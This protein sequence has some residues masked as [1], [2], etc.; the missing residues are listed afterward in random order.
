MRHK[1]AA[2]KE[3]CKM[4]AGHLREQNGIYQMI[5]SW[6]GDDGRRHSKSL[7]TGL[8][9]KGNKKRDEAMLHKTRSE[10]HPDADPSNAQLTLN[11]FLEK[12]LADKAVL[13]KP[14]I[15]ADYA[16]N[17]RHFITPY[18]EERPVK[19]QDLCPSDLDS[20]FLQERTIK[21]TPTPC[22]LEI[23]KAL[24]L[25]LSYAVD[26]GLISKNPA[27][28]LNPCTRS[29]Q[30][31][32]TDFLLDWLRMMEANVRLSTY[33]GYSKAIKNRIIP[34]FEQVHPG[35]RLVDV[36]AKQIQDYY[37]HEALD[38]HLSVATIRRRHANIRKALQYA[39]RTDLIPSNPAVKVELPRP[40]KYKGHFYNAVQL[41][42]TFQ[43]FKDDPAEFGVLA[44]A[45][46]G[47]RR[48]EI[49]GLKWD[50][51]D[52]DAKT[53]TIRHTVTE[54]SVDGKTELY[55]ADTTKTK[56]SYRILPLVPPFEQIL[57]K[58]KKEQEINRKLCGNSYCQ[59]Y[60]DYI[61]VNQLGELIKPGYLSAHVPAVLVAH[62]MPRIRF[63]D[64]RHSCA[65]L[66]FSQGISL[67]EIQAWLG[68]STIST[69]ANIYTHLDENS[70]LNSAEAII[71][72]LPI[73]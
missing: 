6:K 53:I 4:V 58:M 70:K 47:L 19:L 50:A 5:L 36:T 61:Y 72:I 41:E 2:Q 28:D 9:V 54:V 73:Q 8:P 45:F 27:V 22:L 34:Y 1:K 46:Y 40:D 30:I 65:T 51:I 43:I 71:S 67:K 25:S 23:H 29:T 48:S 17:I 32:F 21:N 16:Y 35:L 7:S 69:T 39:Y 62:Q 66:L 68:H 49:V 57:V 31:L 56:S 18:F 63:H 42:K 59:D 3:V 24:V 15:Y 10:F 11:A 38:N 13:M 64:L 55:I 33:A 44:A 14:D 26:L 52:F 20:Y 60:L 37:T 12:W